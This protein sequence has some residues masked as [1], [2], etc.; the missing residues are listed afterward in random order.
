MT[1]QEAIVCSAY[2]GV[3]FVKDFSDVH[4]YIEEI[5]G[6]PVWTHEMASKELWAEI[7]EKARPDF[8]EILKNVEDAG[9]EK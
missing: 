6:R 2:T 9:R 7:K 3:L 4:R 1:K 8:M 5:M